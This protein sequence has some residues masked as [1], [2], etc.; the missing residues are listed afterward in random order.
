MTP[1][2]LI[3]RWLEGQLTPDSLKWL[4]GRRDELRS[5]FTDRALH[6]TLGMIPRR[7]GKADLS[8]NEAD[9]D[10]DIGGRTTEMV[11]DALEREGIPI[12]EAETGGCCGRRADGRVFV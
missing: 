3:A 4:N 9:L 7:L 12:L 10:L 5:R 8:L 11:E 1:V 6:I 2:E